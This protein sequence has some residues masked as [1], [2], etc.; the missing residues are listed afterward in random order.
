V[1]VAWKDT[2]ESRRALADSLPFLKAAEQ[3]TVVEVCGKDELADARIRTADV[4]KY[5]QRHGVK[6][7]AK[8][9]SAPPDRVSAELNIAAQAIG[10]DLIVAGAYGH[11]RLGEWM[12]GGVTY[13]LLHAP[14]RFVLLSH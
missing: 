12:F 13:D 2:R 6:A 10:A 4:V 9:V 11:T 5:L 7:T 1:V 8:A 14:E 3:V